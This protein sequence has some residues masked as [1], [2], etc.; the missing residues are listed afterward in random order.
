MTNREEQI[1]DTAERYYLNNEQN[2]YDDERLSKAF[3][4]GAEW[5]DTNPYNEEIDEV[6][7]DKLATK[8]T[9]ANL[10]YDFDPHDHTDHYGTNANWASYKNGW[11]DA[12]RKVMEYKKIILEQYNNGNYRNDNHCG[13]GDVKE[14]IENFKYQKEWNEHDYDVVEMHLSPK[15]AYQFGCDDMKQKAFD[16]FCNCTC[17]GKRDIERYPECKTCELYYEFEKLIGNKDKYNTT[18]DDLDAIKELFSESMLTP[19]KINTIKNAVKN[20][21]R[22]QGIKYIKKHGEGF[23]NLKSA[24]IYYDVY[25]SK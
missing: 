13:C 20:M 6:E 10:G 9:I 24:A 8:N 7:L 1:R 19:E 3:I 22:V 12:Y 2:N 15:A 17:G 4:R 21:T 23:D 5:A 14:K 16:S 18:K 25:I 11:K